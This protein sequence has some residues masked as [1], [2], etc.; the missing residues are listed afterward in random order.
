VLSIFLKRQKRAPPPREQLSPGGG[1]R[2]YALLAEFTA[3]KALAVDRLLEEF[4][5]RKFIELT[6]GG[7]SFYY[8]VPE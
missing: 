7:V 1:I 6:N 3:W 2:L 5:R 4:F 8:L